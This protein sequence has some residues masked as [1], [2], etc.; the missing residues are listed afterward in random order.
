[1]IMKIPKK[2]AMSM[3]LLTIPTW[4]FFLCGCNNLP[5]TTS[6]VRGEQAVQMRFIGIATAGSGDP[7]NGCRVYA[8]QMNGYTQTAILCKGVVTTASNH[9]ESDDNDSDASD[10]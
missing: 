9:H 1:M 7:I 4:A 2:H 8:F 3:A 10:E 5:N 6:N